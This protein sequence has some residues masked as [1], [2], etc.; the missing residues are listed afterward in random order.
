MQ[1]KQQSTPKPSSS[2]SPVDDCVM[3]PEGL[4]TQLAVDERRLQL[5][6]RYEWLHIANDI[7]IALWFIIGSIFFFYAKLSY[8]GTWLFVLGSTQ[9]MI[10]PVIRILHKI[11]LKDTITQRIHF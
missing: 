9:M 5:Q 7:V 1:G 3:E 11:H 8:A 10:G 4:P 2:Q 6:H